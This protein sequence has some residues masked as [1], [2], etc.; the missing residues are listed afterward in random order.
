MSYQ[1]D[2]DCICACGHFYGFGIPAHGVG[3]RREPDTDC[4]ECKCEEFH[5]DAH[6]TL[7]NWQAEEASW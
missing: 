2:P 5:E 3:H 1:P 6:A 7:A 4:L